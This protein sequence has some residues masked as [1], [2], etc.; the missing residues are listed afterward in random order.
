MLYRKKSSFLKGLLGF[1][2][3]GLIAA[4]QAQNLSP[5]VTE[6][7]SSVPAFDIQF[8]AKKLVI[9]RCPNTEEEWHRFRD[10]MIDSLLAGMKR[11]TGGRVNAPPDFLEQLRACATPTPPHCFQRTHRLLS[12]FFDGFAVDNELHLRGYAT[13]QIPADLLEPRFL[14]AAQNE[15][16]LPD[17]LAYLNQINQ[18]LR[19]DLR[20][21]FFTF[22]GKVTPV[23]A[24]FANGRLLVYRDNDHESTFWIFSYLPRQFAQAIH[25]ADRVS[26]LIGVASV[27]KDERGVLQS[28]F[29]DYQ[30]QHDEEDS[31]LEEE[32][33][34]HW[35]MPVRSNQCLACHKGGLIAIDAASSD[36]YTRSESIETFNSKIKYTPFVNGQDARDLGPPIGQELDRSSESLKACI[37]K[38]AGSMVDLWTQF[39]KSDNPEH[40]KE[41]LELLRTEAMVNEGMACAR[42]HQGDQKGS[43]LNFPFFL[44]QNPFAATNVQIAWSSVYNNGAPS[45]MPVTKLPLHFYEKKAI[46]E[47]LAEEY[48]GDF[49]LGSTGMFQ[50]WLTQTPCSYD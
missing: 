40:Q 27:F 39:L 36:G 1:A 22:N 24:T 7:Q 35:R 20:Y 17:A 42:C 2:L 9:D 50:K 23:D 28:Y 32:L 44:K 41:G 14:R 4:A 15:D 30:Y 43:V 45:S 5:R 31:H 21:S 29:F 6:A 10:E 38:G 12:T 11:F 13:T 25:R 37:K 47:C 8:T 33:T 18:S 26:H 49:D 46:R 16:T 3:M 19:A 34:K 48:Y